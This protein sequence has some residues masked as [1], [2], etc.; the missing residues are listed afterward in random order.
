MILSHRPLLVIALAST[1]LFGFVPDSSVH[2]IFTAPP[3]GLQ[4][5]YNGTVTVTVNQAG[6]TDTEIDIS[7][8]NPS[9]LSVPSEV[10]IPA[11]ETEVQFQVSATGTGTANITAAANGY[12]ATSRNFV[13][14]PGD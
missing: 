13:I 10:D 7:T 2:P 5:G 14:S 9:I 12:Y 1:A 6:S 3:S 8:D 4:S 11:G